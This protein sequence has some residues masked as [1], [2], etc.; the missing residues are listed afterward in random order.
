MSGKAA[1][2]AGIQQAIAAYAQ[3]LDDG[4]TDDVIATFC[5]DGSAEFPGSGRIEGHAA[6]HATYSQLV[7]RAP[8][9][10]VLVN[11]RVTACADDRASAVSDLVLFG[12]GDAGWSIGL[13]G[14][15][16]DTLRCVDGE[17]RFQT[18]SLTFVE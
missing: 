18:R 17:W 14:R 2:T 8:Q 9:R 13:V 7:P 6:L 12:R 10:H 3:A 4:R 5:E 16:A 15:Y 11:T 1:A